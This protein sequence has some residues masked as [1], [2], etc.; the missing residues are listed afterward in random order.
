[1]SILLTLGPFFPLPTA[2]PEAKG[3]GAGFLPDLGGYGHGD[4]TSANALMIIQTLEGRPALG[5][6]NRN[7]CRT[8]QPEVHASRAGLHSATK[9]ARAAELVCNDIVDCDGRFGDQG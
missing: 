9:R 4:E 2:L 7:A 6:A 1:M 8:P 3:A 5:W